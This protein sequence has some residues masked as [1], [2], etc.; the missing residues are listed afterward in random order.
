MADPDTMVTGMMG[1]VV[2]TSSIGLA[3]VA[4]LVTKV[5]AEQAADLDRITSRSTH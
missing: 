2:V 5:V 3:R 4:K 1:Q